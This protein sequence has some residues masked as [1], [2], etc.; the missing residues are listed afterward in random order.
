MYSRNL[1]SN[2][3]SSGFAIAASTRGWALIGPGPISSRGGGSRSSN[4]STMR[5]VLQPVA[6]D[7]DATGDPHFLRFHM[8]NEFFQGGKTAWPAREP[9][10]QPDRH[11]AAAFGV[12]HVEG[13]LEVVEELLSGIEALRGGEAH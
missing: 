1:G 13:I 6:R 2:W 9:A 3:P 5:V 4:S 10:V 7:V 8:T 11:H 12:E